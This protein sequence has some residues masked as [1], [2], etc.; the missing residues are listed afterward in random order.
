[1]AGKDNGLVLSVSAS[2]RPFVLVTGPARLAFR[3]GVHIRSWKQVFERSVGQKAPP[4]SQN[5]RS[6]TSKDLALR[7]KAVPRT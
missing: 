2:L 5:A 6:A 7:P 3:F 1:M 4:T